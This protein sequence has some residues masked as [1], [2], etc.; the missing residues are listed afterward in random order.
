LRVSGRFIDGK[1]T[2]V[3]E[4]AYGQALMYVT[5]LPGVDLDPYLG[6]MVELNGP[7]VYRGDV[8]ANYMTVQNAVPAP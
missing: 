8:R 2:Y 1:T 6:R 7:L 5:A 4:T 3:L